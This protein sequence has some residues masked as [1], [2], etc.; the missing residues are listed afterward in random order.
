MRWRRQPRSELSDL[1]DRLVVPTPF[2]LTEFC[3]AIAEDRG[4]PLHLVPVENAAGADLPC[5]LW[6]S[7]DTADLIFY[8]AGAAPILKTQIV[9][10]EISHMLLDHVSPEAGS[11]TSLVAPAESAG[12]ALSPEAVSAIATAAAAA[13]EAEAA[14]R[15]ADLELGLATDRLMALLA[16]DGYGSRQE[17]DAESLATLI[18]ERATRVGA[19]AVSPCSTEVLSRLNDALGHPARRT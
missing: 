14:A 7:L 5:G 11:L 18:L 6:V 19:E 9:L 16:R 15:A 13:I 4:R 3:A 8:E 1:V 2:D 17:A 10:H 12:P